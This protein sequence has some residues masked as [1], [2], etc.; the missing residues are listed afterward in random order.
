VKEAMAISSRKA[1]CHREGCSHEV[2]R[3]YKEE[4]L[5]MY[6]LKKKNTIT[7]YEKDKT[8]ERET[9]NILKENS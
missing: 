6:L 4:Q 2:V 9:N 7:S 3:R 5:R 1:E 8:Y